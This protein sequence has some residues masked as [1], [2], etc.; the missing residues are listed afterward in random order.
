METARPRAVELRREGAPAPSIARHAN[1]QTTNVSHV[2]RSAGLIRF[3]EGRN[4][5]ADDESYCH[6]PV[7]RPRG[8]EV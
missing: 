2:G 5:H 8:F 7:W 4:R 6:S 3:F 1:R